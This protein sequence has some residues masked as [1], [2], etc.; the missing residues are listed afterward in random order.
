MPCAQ[1]VPHVPE[2]A[3]HQT[4]GHR[5]RQLLHP[6]FAILRDMWQKSRDGFQ[7]YVFY[8]LDFTVDKNFEDLHVCKHIELSILDPSKLIFELQL[9]TR[10]IFRN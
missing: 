6:A 9:I 1:H 10:L 8:L 7:Y 2:P 3:V 5:A 4:E